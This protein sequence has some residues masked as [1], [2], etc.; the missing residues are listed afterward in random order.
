[1]PLKTGS[2]DLWV[3]T[4]A[5]LQQAVEQ[6]VELAAPKR[7]ILFGSR[8]RGLERPDSDADLLVIEEAVGDQAAE[9]TRLRRALRTLRMPVDV[10][11][12]SAEKFDYWADTPGNV[13][14]E[15]SHDGRVLYEAA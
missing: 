13:Y 6:I 3:V 11:V 7:V 1:M 12:V 8:A 4:S 9:M 14:F 15:A 5:K 10:L 2:N